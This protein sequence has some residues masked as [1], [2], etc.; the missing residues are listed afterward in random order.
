MTAADPDVDLGA[1]ESHLSKELGIEVAGTEVLAD[2]LNLIV[3]ISTPTE[4]RAYTFRRANK[5]RHTSLFNELEREY[6]L[7]ER[8]G[9][10]GIPAPEPVLFCDDASVVGDPF[11]V[12][13]HLDGEPFPWGSDLPE[14]Y[15]NPAA[16]ER[17]GTRLIETLAAIHSLD[18]EQF[19]PVCDRK[20]PVD[21]VA[22]ASDRL[23]VATSVT[24]REAP[25]LRAVGDWLRDNAPAESRTTLVH[26]D[27]RP[28][29]VLFDGADRPEITGVLDWETAMLG[30]PLTELGYFLLD[31]RDGDDPT[32]PLDDL[33]ARYAEEELESVRAMNEQGHSPFTAKPGSPTRQELV[34][35][36]EDLT[37]IPFEH[38]RYYRAHAA[39]MLATVWADLH[40]LQVEAGEASGWDPSIDYMAMVATAII[41]GAYPL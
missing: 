27:Y 28:G 3:A 30:D 2:G 39:F 22:Q 29:N 8:L 40:R 7:L 25:R 1:L 32:L 26:G 33:E 18:V 41:D 23:D 10:I 19:E 20:T 24:G 14:R 17:I 21:Q 15:R 35:R 16:R 11:F 6:R 38:D 37:G 13:T 31:W 4:E 34:D 36:Y 12:T 9:V 5:L